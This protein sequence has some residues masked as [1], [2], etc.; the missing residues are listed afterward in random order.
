MADNEDDVAVDN[1]DNVDAAMN[2][3][4]L[5]ELIAA[6]PVAPQAGG[7]KKLAS[8]ESTGGAEW[9]TW[10]NHFE[11]VVAINNHWNDLRQRR[12]LKAAMQGE[13]ARLTADINVEPQVAGAAGA[14]L[15]PDPEFHIQQ[16]LDAYQLRFMPAAAG[17]IA[18]VEFHAASQRPDEL[19]PQFHGRCREMFARAYPDQ[20]AQ[21][22]ALLITTFALGLND[23]ETSRFVL[24]RD[25]QTYTEA[26]NMAQMKNA[27]EASLA[28]RHGKGV[29]AIEANVGAVG[30]GGGR[31]APGNCW[32][33]N[34]AAHIRAD[35][36]DWK[37]AGGNNRPQ[38]GGGGRRQRGRKNNKKGPSVQAVNGNGNQGGSQ[39]AAGSSSS[40]SLG[41]SDPAPGN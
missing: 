10:R 16:A 12:E 25:P 7:T 20:D 31:A 40:S 9:R 15:V 18:R 21:N 30:R 26:S 32:H 23:T 19:I 33:C 3:Q 11:T 35:C 34:S 6:I 24:D 14:G 27:T 1:A 39:D 2:A 13:A 22:S 37:K 8:L 36:P 41:G 29:H 5:A 38:T 17:R 28:T 4:Q